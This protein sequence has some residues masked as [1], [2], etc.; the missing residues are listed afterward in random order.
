MELLVVLLLAFLLLGPSKL[1]D[2]AKGLGKAMREVRR[3][4]GE[5][6]R[7]MEEGPPKAPD[8]GGQGLGRQDDATESLGG[9]MRELRRS[10]NEVARA[11]D[12][13]PPRP[14]SPQEPR[15]QD[16]DRQAPEEKR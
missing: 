14:A 5:V 3:N 16:A 2:M 13:E 15:T 8:Q 6:T 11:F 10:V 1:G 7:A 9:A 4:V 12:E